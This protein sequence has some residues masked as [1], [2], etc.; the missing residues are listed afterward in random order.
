VG[1][2]VKQPEPEVSHSPPSSAKIKKQWSCTSTN[3]RLHGLFMPKQTLTAVAAIECFL[4]SPSLRSGL[5]LF[6]RPSS[7]KPTTSCSSFTPVSLHHHYHLVFITPF[8]LLI[9]HFVF[10][11]L[12]ISL[13][14]NMK[15][16]AHSAIMC[17][18]N[19]YVNT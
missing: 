2:G 8:R 7:H 14:R 16:A 17:N 5:V 15:G 10:R 11:T 12:T 6:V 9:L 19:K 1:T 13:R 3:T 4:L 18:T